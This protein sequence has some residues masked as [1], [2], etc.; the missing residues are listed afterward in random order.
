MQ[1][2]ITYLFKRKDRDTEDGIPQKIHKED[3]EQAESQGEED[4]CQEKEAAAGPPEK[5]T[6]DINTMP[7]THPLIWTKCQYEQFKIKNEWLYAQHG[8]LGCTP[9][10][11]V[12]DLGL[13]ASSGVNEAEGKITPFGSSR[14]VQLLSLCKK[15]HEH[16]KLPSTQ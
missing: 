7:P 15:I 16:R 1:R 14:D 2:K 3:F 5:S 8:K 11:D 9:C 12:K 4:Q 6:G 10:H 13:M